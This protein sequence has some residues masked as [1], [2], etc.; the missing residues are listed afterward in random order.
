MTIECTCVQQ[1]KGIIVTWYTHLCQLIQSDQ[2]TIA[3]KNVVLWASAH[4]RPQPGKPLGNFGLV[5][6]SHEACAATSSLL[7]TLLA[8][9][10]LV[11]MWIPLRVLGISCYIGLGKEG[12]AQQMR[13]LKGLSE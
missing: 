7:L 10:N 2:L 9:L 8:K 11:P 13:G 3:L 1:S 4:C 6:W 12:R 5:L